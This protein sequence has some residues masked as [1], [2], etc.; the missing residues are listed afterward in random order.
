MYSKILLI[1]IGFMS[2]VAQASIGAPQTST[3]LPLLSI[4]NVIPNY[5]MA[6]GTTLL[7]IMPPTSLG[8]VYE[9]WKDGNVMIMSAVILAFSLAVGSYIGGKFSHLLTK[10]T[11]KRTMGIYLILM[12]IYIVYSTF[13]S[14][15]KE[16]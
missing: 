10:I 4:L 9:Y 15:N 11:Q 6:L 12:G 7:A 2:G 13:V 8:A 14:K 1:V 5:K 3:I 16:K